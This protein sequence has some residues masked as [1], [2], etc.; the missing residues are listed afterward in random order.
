MQ[1]VAAGGAARQIRVS[2]ELSDFCRQA[3]GSDPRSSSAAGLRVVSRSFRIGER[4]SSF[5]YAFA[6]VLALFESQHNAW[7]HAAVTVAVL[8]AAA[9]FGLSRLEWCLIVLAIALVWAAEGVNTALEL[10]ADAVAPEHHPL[11]GRAKDVAAAA[12]LISALGAA[13]VG[14]LIFGP[15]LLMLFSGTS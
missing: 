7:I 5:R 8:I 2:D 12:V 6:G 10:L 13:V 15:R 11:V 9:C 14:I 1:F 4:I 3:C